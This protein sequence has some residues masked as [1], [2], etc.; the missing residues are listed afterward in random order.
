MFNQNI[1]EKEKCPECVEKIP[2]RITYKYANNFN[3]FLGPVISKLIESENLDLFSKEGSIYTD[4]CTN[5]TLKGIDMPLKERLSYLYLKDYKTKIACNDDSCEILEINTK[6]STSTC[7]CKL[8]NTFEQL[9]QSEI[10]DITKNNQDENNQTS[11]S[12]SEAFKIVK[13]AKNGFKKNN[14][15]SNGGFFI[16]GGAIV[17]I[18]I[19][20]I[21]YIVYSKVININKGANPPAKL[22][23]RILILSDW[24][25][26]NNNNDKEVNHNIDNDLI[27]SRDEDDGNISEEDLTFSKKDDE[28]SSFSID[29]EI[30]AKKHARNIDNKGLSEKKSHKILVLLSN[31]KNGRKSEKDKKSVNSSEEHEFL[32]TDTLRKKDKKKNFLQ[33]YWEVVSIKQHIINFFSAFKC[34]KITE[35]YI[36][37][38]MRFIRSLFMIV[39]AFMLNVLFLNQNYYSD[40]FTYFNKEYKLITTKKEEFIIE[41]EEISDLEIPEI[42]L[43][44]YAFFHTYI[45]AIIIFAALLVAQFIIGVIFFSLRVNVVEAI[46]SNNL[47]EINDLIVKTKIKNAIFFFICLILLIIFLISFAGFGGIYGGSFLDYFIPGL[48]SL[49]VL[50]IFPFFWSIILAIVRYVG[51]KKGKKGCYDFSQFFLF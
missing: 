14:I 42:E 46:R 9:I 50:Q 12:L 6:Q 31:K 18:I 45:N 51:I 40:K 20:F 38:P 33:I 22:K 32:S 19:C 2:Y 11:D 3:N 26:N 8:G 39:L 28:N 13:C 44:K 16:A 41:P 35:S 34:C 43:W 30:G 29:T 7:E 10:I 24:E 1:N 36:P 49:A 17:L 21:I 23:H 37:L 47:S 4:F 5:V 25:K 27:Q 15:L 48:I